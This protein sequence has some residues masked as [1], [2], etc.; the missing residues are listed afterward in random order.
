MPRAIV[1]P[2]LMNALPAMYPLRCT[3]QSAT[4]AA[5]AY[6][7]LIET[8]SNFAGHVNLPCAFARV[9]GGQVGLTEVR[10]TDQ[11][12]DIEDRHIALRGYFPDITPQMRA[13]VS[14]ETYEVVGVDHDSHR[15]TTRVR[16]RKVE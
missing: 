3:I 10:R 4:K 14:G 7:E 1:D 16:V 2:R 13:I 12:L 9:G 5:D 15:Q 8:W 11:L 6:H